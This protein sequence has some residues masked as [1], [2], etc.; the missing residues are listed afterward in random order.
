[1]KYSVFASA[2]ILLFAA[3]SCSRSYVVDGY[4]SVKCD[5]HTL[6]TQSRPVS[7]IESISVSRGISVDYTQSDSLSV[8]VEAPRDLLDNIITRIN[9]NELTITSEGNLGQ[10]SQYVRVYVSAPAVSD[11]EVKAGGALT[12]K[13]KY[14]MPGE[15]EVELGSGGAFTAGSLV[16]SGIEIEAASGAA[17]A[18]K[19]IECEKLEAD[20][21]SGA[22]LSLS[23]SASSVDLSASSGAVVEASWLKALSGTVSADAGATVSVNI[24]DLTR[25][26]KSGGASVENHAR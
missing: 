15:V 10:C 13:G 9:G 4:T 3:A 11:F 8:R 21:S 14:R 1:M 26:N 24:A 25:L 23:G 16:A 5:P 17:V 2:A 6:T 18:V 7:D 20:A 12:V 19:G 22:S